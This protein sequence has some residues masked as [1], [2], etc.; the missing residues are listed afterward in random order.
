MEAEVREEKRCHTSSLEDG[1]KDHE[2][3]NMMASS[4]WKRQGN[5]FSPKVSRWIQVGQHLHF[6]PVKLVSDFRLPKRK[7]NKS[8]LFHAT[9][10]LIFV[11][12]TIVN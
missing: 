4:S 5:G 8:A 1:G 11:T 10:F 7:N 2:S 3:I 12:T 6:S 9:K